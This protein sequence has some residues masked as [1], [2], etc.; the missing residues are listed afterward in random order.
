MMNKELSLEE[1]IAEAVRDPKNLGE[2][3]N[4]DAIGTVG[5]PDCGDMLRMWLKFKDEDG[6]KVIDRATFQ[7]FGCQ[8]AIAVA[9]V[10]TELLTGK[11]VEEALQMKGEDLSEP[12]GPLP[13][14]KIHCAQLVEEAL[15]SA[16]EV[17][18]TNETE[19]GASKE[20]LNA[21][22]PVDPTQS[23]APTLLD[24]LAEGTKGTKKK[25]TLISPNKSGENK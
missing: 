13:P 1:K 24:Q 21:P 12:L 14:M 5:S 7:S 3:T 9:S 25:I 20:N 18:G 2:M 4:A 22:T 11:S 10:A 15:K 16:L 19:T 8:T 17:N 6:K 23:L